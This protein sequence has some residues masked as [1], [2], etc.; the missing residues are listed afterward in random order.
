[1]NC[2]GAVRTSGGVSTGGGAA[3]AAPDS[4]NAMA[5]SVTATPSRQAMRVS[6]RN[7]LRES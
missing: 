6:T 4:A 5:A 2:A 3:V 1:M 7:R